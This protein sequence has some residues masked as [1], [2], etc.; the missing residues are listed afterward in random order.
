LDDRARADRGL[1]ERLAAARERAGLTQLAAARAL[2][3][4][5]S[6]IAKLERGKRQLRFL[7]GL[8]LAKLYGV[9]PTSLDVDTGAGV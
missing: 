3:V 4:P 6:T 5:Q 7:E 8:Q 1:G 2:G 9:M